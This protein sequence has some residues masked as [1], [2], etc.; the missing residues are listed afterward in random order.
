ME[1]KKRKPIIVSAY[2]L[3]NI[4]YGMSLGTMIFWFGF[5]LLHFIST[6]VN[7]PIVWDVSYNID[8]LH[9]LGPYENRAHDFYVYVAGSYMMLYSNLEKLSFL[10]FAYYSILIIVTTFV[11]SSLRK[12][13]KNIYDGEP[14]VK[15]NVL[16]IRWIGIVLIINPVALDITKRIL[17]DSL[18]STVIVGVK[19]WNSEYVGYF[20]KPTLSSLDYLQWLYMA[21][22]GLIIIVLAEVFIYGLQLKQEN[23]LTV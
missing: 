20:Y 11:V 16:L 17:V 22:G 1:N 13:L 4:L 19:Q 21:V 8:L 15:E 23:D 5:Y 10:S 3:M 6:S 18:P 7:I 14:F 9:K 2:G 12:I